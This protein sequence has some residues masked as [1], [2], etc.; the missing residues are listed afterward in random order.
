MK[1][2]PLPL[3]NMNEPRELL[4]LATCHCELCDA[5]RYAEASQPAHGPLNWALEDLDGSTYGI[6]NY[7][8]YNSR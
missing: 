2:L 7:A 4:P 3:L 6:S 8:R 5:H 1:Q